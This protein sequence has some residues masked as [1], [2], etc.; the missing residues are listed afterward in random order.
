MDGGTWQASVHGVS[1]SQARLNYFTF[2]F[3]FHVL[4]KE[5]ATHSS[6]LAWRIPGT[7]EPGGL[8]SLGSDRVGHDWSDLE[9]A[10]ATDR[11]ELISILVLAFWFVFAVLFYSYFRFF[12]C[13]LIIFLNGILVT[14]S[15]LFLFICCRFLIC[16]YYGVY[17]CLPVGM[18]TCFKLIIN[19]NHVL[20]DLLIFYSYPQHFVFFMF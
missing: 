3:H 6:I 18:S 8:H 13:G 20:N 15:L 19:I 4:E 1:K 14:L 9:A 5:I 17:V 10:A 7:V 11:Y 16:S 2:T 12:L